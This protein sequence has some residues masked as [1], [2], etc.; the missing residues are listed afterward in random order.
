MSLEHTEG[1]VI[2]RVDLDFK[3]WHTFSDGTQIRLERDY[4]NLNRRETQPINAICI[5]GEGIKPGSEVLIHHNATTETY[6]INNYKPLSGENISGNV[7]YFSIP[8]EQCFI[9]RDGDVWKPLPPYET[10]LRVFEPYKGVLDGIYPQKLKHT[11]FVTSGE[12]KDKVVATEKAVDYEIV[13]QD[14]NG[15]EGRIIRFRPFGDPKTNK[16]EEAIAI[17]NELTKKVLNG[18]LLIGLS[19]TDCKP[20]EISAY[21]D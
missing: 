10:A 6:K 20:F 5:S 9:W 17:M 19:T 13:F 11:L 4:E 16:E 7:Q 21:A 12:L 15:M 2:I 1:R 18:D 3:N 8:S 14:I